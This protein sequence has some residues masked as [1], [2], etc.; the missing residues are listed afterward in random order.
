MGQ[1][2][3]NIVPAKHE[4]VAN[5]N[6]AQFRLDAALVDGYQ[7]QVRGTATDIANQQ[8]AAIR[9]QCFV[10]GKPVVTGCLGLFQQF[11]LTQ[12]GLC[13]RRKGKGPGPFIEGCG[14]G[15]N[16][17]LLFKGMVGKL[18]VPGHANMV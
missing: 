18:V 1:C 6:A 4:V 9:R 5:A 12:P 15:D 3:I 16:Q 2:Q 13:C 7:R 11:D 8:Q 14:H 17:R 10:T